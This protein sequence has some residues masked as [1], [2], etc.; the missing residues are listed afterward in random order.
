MEDQVFK[1]VHLVGIGGINMSGVAKL[2][3]QAGVRVSGSDAEESENTQEL[4]RMG[5]EVKIGHVAENVPPDADL[6]IYS[7]AVPESNVERMEGRKLNVRQLT[8]FQFLGEWTAGKQVVLITG[9]HGKSTTTALAGLM[10]LEAKKDPT[11]I[12]GSKVPS[13]P[14]G[15]I[16]L[17][18]SDL[19]VIEGDEYARH[20]LEFHPNALVLNNIELDHTDIF[21]DL[22]AL[23]QAFRELL[24]QVKDD[25]LIVA[26]ADDPN[27]GTLLGEERRHLEARG[28]RIKTFG[29]GA[30]AVSQI[31]DYTVKQEEQV[32]ALRDERGLVTR[33]S[34]KVPGRMN[35]LNATAA[36]TL[37]MA[38]GC[39]SEVVR[40]VLGVFSGIWRRFER[41]SD[42]DGI[43]VISDYGHHP[44]AVKQTLEA[45][46]SFYPGRRI[47]LC[48]QPHHKNRTKHLFL[49][50]IPAFDLADAL[51][52]SEI[53]DVKGR[54]AKDDQDISS[55]DLE[56]AILHHDADRGMARAVGYVPNPQE[57][58][59]LLKRWRKTG[60]I[61]IVMGAGDIYKIAPK[62]L[63]N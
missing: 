43:L 13:F 11:V 29:F 62:V 2:L 24:Q 10:L 53:Y 1:Q 39:P 23:V 27:V 25:G 22:P 21:P 4:K 35:I 31:A 38:L 55:R 17:G 45:A 6:L 18:K 46:R 52:L 61:I 30:H 33:F 28:V 14:D 49:D 57:A 36:S 3:L 5:I 48:F 7:S 54:E 63:D 9:T 59:T 12:V 41:V 34:L 40:A 26:N 50:F 56:E 44:T 16:R 42:R 51:I 32:F 58:L 60:D 15:N 47:V 37:V 20:F 8:N 19:F